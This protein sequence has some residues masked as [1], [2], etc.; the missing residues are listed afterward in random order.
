MPYKNKERMKLY[1][2]S[3]QRTKRHGNWRQI[4]VNYHFLCARCGSDNISDFHEPFGELREG[5]N[6]DNNGNS[7]FQQREP[8]CF[9]CHTQIHDGVVAQ[10][11]SPRKYM[12]MVIED[13]NIEMLLC[14][15]Y[16]FWCTKY[17]V[18]DPPTGGENT[19]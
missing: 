14:G 8:V 19:Q 12:S 10:I 3:W 4:L 6:C 16:N 9:D 1:K 13:A 17:G 7:K 2:R 18:S 11:V 5:T 15:G